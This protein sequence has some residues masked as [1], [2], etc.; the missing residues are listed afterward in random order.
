MSD[1]KPVRLERSGAVA[2]LILDR[3][4]RRNPINAEAHALLRE[5]LDSIA[6]DPGV[7]ALVLTGAGGYFCSGQDLAERYGMLAEGEVDLEASLREN[8]NP[9][10]RR[11]LALPFP[12]IAAVEGIAAGAGLG[13]LL[14]ADIVLAGRSTRFQLPFSRVGLGPDSG[15]SWTLARQVGANRA[16]ALLLTGERFDAEQ[17]ER[18]GVVWRV[19]D[20][21]DS[22]GEAE[23]LAARLAKG[24]RLAL[25]ETR[26]RVHEAASFDIEE[27][28]D[29]EAAMQGKL[30][31]HPD[32]RTA[33]NAFME[34][35]E[36]EFE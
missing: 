14:A 30:G 11:L 4:E 20:D 8:Y 12:V 6:D 27:A 16:M 9:L 21:G 5:A 3:P 15:L 18:W 7:R 24:P 28:L 31:L 29:G 35:R 26:R 2:S 34:K 13:L 36:P 32:Y 33:V 1:A 23:A 22:A 10:I 19:M 25:A 17:A